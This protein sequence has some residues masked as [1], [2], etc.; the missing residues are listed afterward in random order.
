MPL[1]PSQKSGEEEVPTI[2]LAD[3]PDFT[4]GLPAARCTGP[5]SMI[6][7]GME[8][9]GMVAADAGMGPSGFKAACCQAPRL[10]VSCRCH[11]CGRAHPCPAYLLAGIDGL[12]R[13]QSSSVTWP[14]LRTHL[15]IPARPT[16]AMHARRHAL[17]CLHVHAPPAHDAVCTAL[18]MCGPWLVVTQ[19]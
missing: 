14:T 11:G 9:G 13:A 2:D 4:P 8:H 16:A 3:S 10:L 19:D 18:L 12:H 7:R 6:V 15:V 17:E 5:T 1:G